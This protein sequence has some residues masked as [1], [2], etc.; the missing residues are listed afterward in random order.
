M[1]L[2]SLEGMFGWQRKADPGIAPATPGSVKMAYRWPVSEQ[3]E[4]C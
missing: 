2:E 1:T 3:A 4:T